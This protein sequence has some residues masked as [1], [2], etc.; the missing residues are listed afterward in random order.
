M[1]ACYYHFLHFAYHLE[2]EAKHIA[3]RS[4][5]VSTTYSTTVIANFRELSL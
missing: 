3:Y 4:E 1:L 5:Y 2:A